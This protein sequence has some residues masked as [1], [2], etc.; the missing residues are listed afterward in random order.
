MGHDFE[1]QIETNVYHAFASPSGVYGNFTWSFTVTILR[2]MYTTKYSR[3]NIFPIKIS[4]NGF[5]ARSTLPGYFMLDVT[6]AK[7]SIGM[8]LWMEMG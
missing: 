3:E 5:L 7:P 8:V 4:Q 2:Q 6:Q 1:K